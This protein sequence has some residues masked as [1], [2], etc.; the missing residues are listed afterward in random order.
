M[1]TRGSLR[2][3]GKLKRPRIEQSG[4]ELPP[5]ELPIDQR[6]RKEVPLSFALSDSEADGSNR[7]G[8]GTHHST[9]PLNTIIPNEVEL[10]TRGDGLILEFVNRTEED[11]DHNLNN[12]THNVRNEPAHTH[13]SGSTG[14]GVSSSSGGSHHQDFPKRNPGG[15]GIVSS[16]RGDMGLT[17][18]FI[19]AWNLTT[20]SILNDAEF[21]RDM[22]INLATPAV[23]Y[24]QNW[25]TETQNQLVDTVRSRN[26]LSDDHKALQQV[27]LGCVSKEADLTEKL[28][29]V[30][31][32]RYDLLDKNRERD[33][34]IKQLEADLASKTSSLTEAK[35][36]VS[37]LKAASHCLQRLLS[38][39][40][41]KKRLS[42]IFNLAIV[43]GWSEGVKAACFEE[44]A[45]AFLATTVDYD[46]TCKTT[47]M[48]L[49]DSFFNKSYPYVEK[50]V[51]SFRLPLGD[52]QNMWQKGTG[53]TLSGNATDV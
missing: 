7:S 21:C 24:Q 29:A 25:L 46:P 48:S 36:A 14:H 10:T 18:P 17:V 50:L 47:F 9:S 34:R 22:M 1:K 20:H 16:L 53:P 8:S 19:L 40:K 39:D 41:Y 52:L 27:H 15:D 31:K 23:R 43:A 4:R 3:R 5:K 2:R 30:E 42:D 51:E 28:D 33:E 11:T 49:F 37:T 45:E 13:A 38:S 12:D 6:R 35:G 44:E 32:E 26:K